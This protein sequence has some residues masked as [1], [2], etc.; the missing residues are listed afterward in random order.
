MLEGYI[1]MFLLFTLHKIYCR[2]NDTR[3]KRETECKKLGLFYFGLFY[4]KREVKD[5]KTYTAK[6]GR[7][8]I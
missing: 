6:V 4:F 5:V 1:L 8:R 3:L 7:S 2:S